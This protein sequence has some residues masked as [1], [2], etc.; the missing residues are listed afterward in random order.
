MDRVIAV[1][2]AGGL[3][4]T[5]SDD[6]NKKKKILIAKYSS[7]KLQFMLIAI[8]IYAVGTLNKLKGVFK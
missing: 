1:F 7:S 4:S 3:S 8:R 6:F 5:S 2:S